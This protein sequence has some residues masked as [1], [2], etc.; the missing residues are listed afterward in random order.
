MSKIIKYIVISAN[1]NDILASK[2]NDSIK[3]GW[4]PFGGVCFHRDEIDSKSCN[5]Y[6]QQ[7][8]VKYENQPT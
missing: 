6:F 4:Q 1:D 5:W 3:I 7:A 8:M 2:V